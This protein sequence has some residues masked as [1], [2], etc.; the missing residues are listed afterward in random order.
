[1]VVVVVAKREVENQEGR[2]DEQDVEVAKSRR[3][4]EAI[5]SLQVPI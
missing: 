5:P 2:A 4:M 1:V 3:G